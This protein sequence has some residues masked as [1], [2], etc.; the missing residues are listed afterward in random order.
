MPSEWGVSQHCTKRMDPR[1]LWQ[2]IWSL[3]AHIVAQQ[4]IPARFIHAGRIRLH[5]WEDE[6]DVVHTGTHAEGG[7]KGGP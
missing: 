4:P 2:G 7:E 1:Y 3:I 6:S 5:F